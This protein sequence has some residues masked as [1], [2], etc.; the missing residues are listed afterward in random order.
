MSEGPDRESWLWWQAVLARVKA[1]EV[2]AVKLTKDHTPILI[3][4]K[5][6]IEKMGGQVRC[7]PSILGSVL[8]SQ[9]A[10]VIE[11]RV[12]GT[13]GI[14][15]SFGD[16]VLCCTHRCSDQLLTPGFFECRRSRG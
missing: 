13:L 3:E 15:R 11:N 8:S 14:S 1:G 7:S 9:C 16:K 10:Q 12:Q 2:K 6:R 5:K 4:E